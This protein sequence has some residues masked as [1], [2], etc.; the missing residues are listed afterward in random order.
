M[1]LPPFPPLL[2]PGR[3][4]SSSSTPT[5]GP[6]SWNQPPTAPQIGVWGVGPVVPVCPSGLPCGV[7]LQ[8]GCLPDL[9]AMGHI[10]PGWSHPSPF[11]CVC[12]SPPWSTTNGRGHCRGRGHSMLHARASTPTI[13]PAFLISAWNPKPS[14]PY[15]CLE[16]R[17]RPPPHL[18]S[19]DQEQHTGRGERVGSRCT[20]TAIC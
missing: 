12:D 2:S 9:L 17:P 16:L 13:G 5:P 1:P 18:P 6:L 8:D 15:G 7:T 10:S 19:V 14:F 20:G 3:C 11:S 4:C